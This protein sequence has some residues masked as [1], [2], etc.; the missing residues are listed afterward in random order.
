MKA[1]AGGRPLGAYIKARILGQ[2]L[3]RVRG[4]LAIED[5]NALVQALA[6][7]GQSRYANN[8]NQIVHLGH[9]GS[10]PLTLEITDEIRAA[11]A[12]KRRYSRWILIAVP[13]SS[14]EI[15]LC[16][17]G[18]LLTKRIRRAPPAALSLKYAEAQ[19]SLDV[20]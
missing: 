8:L 20:A 4:G 16:N 9:I 10:L 17:L 1:E 12:D 7:L 19:E 2:P 3:R 11:C 6:L 14:L 18:L 15:R 5:R 13:I